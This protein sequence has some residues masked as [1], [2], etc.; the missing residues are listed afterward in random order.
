MLGVELAKL[1]MN[2]GKKFLGSLKIYRNEKPKI[3]KITNIFNYIFN[4]FDN[5]VI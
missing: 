4:D 3:T 5:F 1:A 2:L